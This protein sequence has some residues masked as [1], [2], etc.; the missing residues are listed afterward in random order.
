MLEFWLTADNLQSLLQ[1]KLRSGEYNA[2]QA[3]DDAMIIYERYII[4]LFIFPIIIRTL[5]PYHHGFFLLFSRY[6][7][8]QA[9]LPLGFD[10]VTRIDVENSICHE[11]GPLPECFSTPLEHILCL[12]EEV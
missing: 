3:L 6:F 8:M 5:F 12:L 7:S 9:S 2:Q 10:D 11:G 4:F 1:D